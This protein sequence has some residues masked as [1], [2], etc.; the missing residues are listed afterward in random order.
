MRR[1]FVLVLLGAV[2]A[3]LGLAAP[4]SSRGPN[5]VTQAPKD[6]C[7]RSP[8]G[9]IQSTTAEW[10]YVNGDRRPRVV[11]GVVRHAHLSGTDLPGTRSPLRFEP[12][13]LQTAP[14]A[15]DARAWYRVPA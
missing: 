15:A 13:D 1:G 8:A 11:E 3:F 6:G 7:Q 10:V 5:P 14:L 2:G 9:L 4:A 12:A